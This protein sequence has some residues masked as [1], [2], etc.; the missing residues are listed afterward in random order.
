MKR[1]EVSVCII[2][3][4]GTMAHAQ[5][6]SGTIVVFQLK[7]NQFSI[8]ADSRSILNGIPNDSEC[9]IMA[10]NSN[11]VG[12]ISGGSGYRNGR[13]VFDP[14]EPWNGLEEMRRIAKG[15]MHT[16]SPS[17]TPT[18]DGIAEAWANTVKLDWANTYAVHP[19]LVIETAR[20]N[21]GL[22][23][24]G[25]FALAYNGTVS[26][27]GR[28]VLFNGGEMT[29]VPHNGRD[30]VL[31]CAAGTLDVFNE[32]VLQTTPRSKAEYSHFSGPS[33]LRVFRLA[34]L[35]RAYD[36][37]GTIGGPIDALELFNDG[38]IRWFARKDNC[39]AN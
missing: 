1:I 35:A 29:V 9:K 25:I 34:N 5:V 10:L 8:A 23:T 17:H 28:T 19:E 32:M 30:C 6:R 33:I 11:F 37:S 31:P 12:A 18:V 14:A 26:L 27:T 15:E 21:Q 2:L 7:D 16:P 20:R 4:G 39:P 3:I 24:N 22:L 13:N 36:H 38:T